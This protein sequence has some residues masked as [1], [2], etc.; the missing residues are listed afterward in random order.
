MSATAE[1][2]K[3]MY[4]AML[5]RFGHQGWWPVA[6]GDGPGEGATEIC[7]GAIL[8]QNTNWTNV[9]KALANLRAA[10]CL[11][12]A[13][14]HGASHEALAALIRPAGYFNVKAKRMKNFMRAVFEAFGDDVE[15][16]LDRPTDTLRRELL[17]INGIGRE[18]ADSI[19]LYAADK[20]SFV[21][22]TYTHRILMRH[23]LIWPEDDYESIKELFETNLADDVALWK[24]YHAQLV[25]VGK[26]YCRPKVRCSG[27]PLEAFD[28][29][30]DA[31]L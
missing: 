16:F 28:H 19:V 9:E 18:T 13:A 26:H 14:L 10:D 5:G 3:Q 2:L 29:D 15:A 17:S 11:S 30:P 25:A 21:V 27:C 31:G 4:E 1:T 22:D 6:A 20:L 23:G 7:V 8:T 24:D 12:V